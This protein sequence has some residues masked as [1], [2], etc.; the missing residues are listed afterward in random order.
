M[1]NC[2]RKL[3]KVNALRILEANKDMR[4]KIDSSSATIMQVLP[5]LVAGGVERGTVDV[6][7]AIINGGGRSIVVS[8]GGPMTNELVRSGSKHIKMN[9]A[10]KN[11]IN[12]WKNIDRLAK[13]IKQNKVDIIHLRSRAPAWSGWVAAKKTNTPFV[14]TF[15]GT[16][17]GYNNLIKRR[18]NK[19][20]TQGV[21]VIAISHF[22]AGHIRQRYGV[23]NSAIRIIPRGFDSENFSIQNISHERKIKL[24]KQ[25]RLPDDKLIVMLP[26]RLTRWKGQINFIRAINKLDLSQIHVL[27][28]GSDQ[29]RV[30]YKNELEMEIKKLKLE[31]TVNI[32][33]HC[34]DMPAAYMLTDVVVSASTE[35]EAFGRVAVEGQAMGRMVVATD[36]GGSKETIL[37]GR[38]GWLVEP[39][40]PNSLADA[41]KICLNMAPQERSVISRNAIT[42]V[43]SKYTN[44]LMC[45]RTLETYNELL[46]KNVIL[47]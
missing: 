12:I 14:T 40:N 17:S 9:V 45:L 25:W 10:S 42:H 19:I 16:Y 24:A 3:V 34:D 21:R 1:L 44:K 37:H 8:S 20:M 13:I 22:I 18:Y 4:Q 28:V 47:S 39:N 33:G 29:G 23:N 46:T 38:T 7:K 32:I 15:H 43:N 2:E 35:P 36:H 26:G 41:I 31:N 11:P 5:N 27:I 30:K 6:A